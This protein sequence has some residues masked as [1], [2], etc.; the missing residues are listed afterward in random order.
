MGKQGGTRVRQGLLKKS[1]FRLVI[2]SAVR[3]GLAGEG[4]FTS[5][6]SFRQLRVST[7][8]SIQAHQKISQHA[9][10]QEKIA[11]ADGRDGRQLHSPPCLPVLP[12]ISPDG[13][14]EAAGMLRSCLYRSRSSKRVRC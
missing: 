14:W 12:T 8:T 13:S 2:E 4:P 7:S 3:F 5:S 6:L 11:R 10:K 1:G 9:T